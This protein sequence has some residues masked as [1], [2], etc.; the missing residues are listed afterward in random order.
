MEYITNTITQIGKELSCDNDNGKII[1]NKYD[2]KVSK[3]IF[4]FDEAITGRKYIALLNPVT[5]KYHIEPIINN[6]VVITTKISAYPGKWNLLLIATDD[7]YEI[8]DNNIDQSKVTYV[9]NSFG[10]IIVRDNFLDESE[11]EK[12]ENPAIDEML[13]ALRIAQDRLENAAIVADENASSASADREHVDNVK[14]SIDNIFEELQNIQETVKDNFSSIEDINSKIESNKKQVE[15]IAIDIT[16]KASAIAEEY[17]NIQKKLQDVQSSIPTR[18]SQLEND[19]HYLEADGSISFGRKADTSVGVGSIA[20]GLDV[21][22]SGQYSNAEGERTRATGQG[23]HAEGGGT[24]ASSKYQHVQGKY[25]VEDTDNKYAHIVGGGTDANNRRNIHTVDWDGNAEYAGDVT[26]NYGGS[27]IPIGAMLKELIDNPYMH[28]NI[29]RGEYLGESITA[30]Q[31]EAIR[32]GTFDGLYIGDYWEKG[33]TKYRIAD[34]DYWL[35]TGHPDKV[36]KHHIVIVPDVCLTI[37]KMSATKSTTDGYTGSLIKTQTLPELKTQLNTM[38]EEHI[39]ERRDILNGWIT[40]DIDLMSEIMLYG[41]NI[42]NQ[43][44]TGTVVPNLHTTAKQQLSL[45][46]LVPQYIC[47]DNAYWLRDITSSTDYALMS[48]AG[49]SGHDPANMEYGVRPVFAVG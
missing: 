43:C 30:E 41:S 44:A 47:A 23:A 27:A 34:I 10:R 2:N 26:V 4:S 5:K 35:Y 39:M 21:E 22:A 49:N 9:S 12:V 8:E 42:Y 31:L 15:D 11:I 14:Q 48:S 16:Q 33:E 1:V 18:A 37:G 3:L 46:R 13:E 28:R 7:D 38:F 40:T 17:E 6:E 20:C 32:N 45:F 24:I 29:F 36:N 19:A 25:N